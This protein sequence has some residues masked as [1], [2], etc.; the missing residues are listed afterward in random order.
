MPVDLDPYLSVPRLAGLALAPDGST[1][2]T[3]LA[4]LSP[5][6]KRYLWALWEVDPLGA[7]GPRRLTAPSVGGPGP[8]F[9]PDGRLLFTAARPQPLDE[10]EADPARD[11]DVP[12]LWLLPAGPGEARRVHARAAAVEQV[13]V[14]RDSGTVV[15]ASAAFPGSASDAADAERA[16]A[17]E[18][19]GVAA[20]L[21][22]SYPVR[23][24]DSDL[25]PRSPH[26]WSAAA[27]SGDA[28]LT[29]VQDRT[30]AA[31]SALVD[32]S[33]DLAPDGSF[34]VTTWLVVGDRSLP[35]TDLVAVDLAASGLASGAPDP[36]PGRDPSSRRTL[37]TGPDLEFGEPVVSPDG[38]WVV[39]S[40]TYMGA[41]DDP[42]DVTLWLTDL[43]D[44]DPAAGR[45]LTPELDLWPHSP[46]W[47]A[48]SAAMF[49]V[50][51]ENGRAPVFRVELEGGTVT[52]LCADGA[53]SD[54]C[55][56]PDGTAIYA[57]RSSFAAPPHLVALDSRTADQQPRLLSGPQG[58]VELPG[59]VVEV[60]AAATDGTAI[61]SWLVLPP[62][63]SEET[64]APLVLWAHGGPLGSWNAWSW[65]WCPHLLAA[66]GYAV[67]LPDPALSTGYGRDF[68]R[69]GWGRW[70]EAPYT[71]LMSAVDAALERPDLDAARTAMMG[72]SFGGYM[73][74]WMAGHTDRFRAI[75]SHAGLWALDQFHGTTDL[76]AWWEREFG[77]PYVD[78]SRYRNNSPHRF[79]DRI[80][81]PMLVIHGERD[82]RVPVGESLRLWT[83]LSRHGVEGKYLL[84]P[85]ENHWVLGPGNARIWYETVLAFLDTHVRGEP[86]VRPVLL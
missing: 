21:F 6:G 57:V 2:V 4:T 84:F 81:T 83:D 34:A 44:P 53:F 61:R 47:S 62:T 5:D 18:S 8:A 42:P 55:P 30:P 17:R 41:P 7:R 71:D 9:L 14:A 86:W 43:S 26:L 27:P 63:A 65:R 13:R 54:V 75:V 1:L 79:V 50:A 11:E 52:R 31:G 73:A 64:P 80:R 38:R 78:P 37:A 16:A 58:E 40:R 74:N 15:L 25:G 49:F 82:F 56:A 69:R 85:G 39:S 70:G 66:A 35:R 33:F 68:V 29:P 3:A 36:G 32:A 72:G 12:A 45:D 22:D 77:D 59:T 67:L 20:V 51:D 23:F 28:S 19:A 24:W 48:D 10:P 60:A 46:R 76:G